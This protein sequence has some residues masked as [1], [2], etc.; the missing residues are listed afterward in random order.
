LL[1]LPDVVV[2]AKTLVPEED[3]AIFEGILLF[4]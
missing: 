2:T 1:E 4:A 3:V